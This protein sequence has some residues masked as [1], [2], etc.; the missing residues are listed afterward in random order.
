MDGCLTNDDA[1]VVSGSEDGKIYFWDLVEVLHLL[2]ATCNFNG[3]AEELKDCVK[4]RVGL[5]FG[6]FAEFCT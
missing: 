2:L 4:C 3:L 6:S 5:N 1:H